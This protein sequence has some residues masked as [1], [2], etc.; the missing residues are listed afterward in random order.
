MPHS[1]SLLLPFSLLSSAYR[2]FRY[3]Y[4]TSDTHKAVCDVSGSIFAA[5]G[6][7]TTGSGVDVSTAALFGVSF[8]AAL[9]GCPITSVV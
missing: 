8:S 4:V 5:S 1:L 6:N 7:F 9:S 3:K 2:T